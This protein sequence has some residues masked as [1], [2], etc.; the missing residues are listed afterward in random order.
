MTGDRARGLAL[1]ALPALVYLAFLDNPFVFE[2]GILTARRAVSRDLRSLPKLLS[3]RAYPAL[4]PNFG[5]MYRPLVQASYVLDQQAWGARRWPR[6]AENLLLHLLVTQAVFRLAR[7]FV[8]VGAAFWSALLF[9]LHPANGEVIFTVTYRGT[10]MAAALGLWAA[11]RWLE[12]PAPPVW[13]VLAAYLVSVMVKEIALPI[14]AVL[15]LGD[16]VLGGWAR[17]RERRL[18]YLGLAGVAAG[19][20]LVRPHL[21]LAESGGLVVPTSLPALAAAVKVAWSTLGETVRLA[22]WPVSLALVYPVPASPA[23]GDP[24]MLVG[25][26]AAVAGMAALAFAWGRWPAV[27][28][29][30]GAAALMHLPTANVVRPAQYPLMVTE[31][32]L[33]LVLAGLAVAFAGALARLRPEERGGWWPVA[34]AVA[35]GLVC[36][37][38]ALTAA[39]GLVWRDGSVIARGY[40]RMLP[41]DSRAHY[42]VAYE[43]HRAGRY[44]EAAGVYREALL[45]P[46]PLGEAWINLGLCE[47][48]LGRRREAEHNFERAAAMLPEDPRPLFNLGNLRAAE[49]RREAAEAAYRE[50]LRRRPDFAEAHRALG[51]LAFKAGRLREAQNHFADFERAR[52]GAP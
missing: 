45:Y 48:H 3:P 37:S 28:W 18:A 52:A 29:G 20:L 40:M 26:T 41:G 39:R 47:K 49:G 4:T 36:A 1:W 13:G 31:R 7:L 33:Y 9:A 10:Q 32:N 27:A 17:L 51:N 42:A 46:P 21:I 15:I 38:A 25:M 24:M 6:R 14:P 8:P 5:G 44:A 35:A 19:Y 43:L 34:R 16:F 22:V 12:R 2:D 11:V 30:L 23:F 50:A